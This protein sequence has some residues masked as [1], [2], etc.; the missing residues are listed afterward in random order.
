MVYLLEDRV[1]FDGAAAADVAAA[2]KDNSSSG[3]ASQTSENN[4]DNSSEQSQDSSS[5]QASQTNSN[6]QDSASDKLTA[7]MDAIL[8]QAQDNG[9]NVIVASS[10]SGELEALIQ[11]ADAHNATLVTFPPRQAEAS[12]V[13]F[14]K[15]EATLTEKLPIQ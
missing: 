1:Y 7:L 5:E 10:D 4:T 2:N 13:S 8:N 9:N 15:S 12:T 14:L 11:A 3:D 6:S